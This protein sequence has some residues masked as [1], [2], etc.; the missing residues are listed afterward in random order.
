MNNM[1][2]IL[3]T[4]LFNK[5]ALRYLSVTPRERRF[6]NYDKAKNILL[7]FESDYAEKNQHIHRVIKQ[8]RQ[9][10]KKVSAWGFID[11]KQVETAIF[12]EFRILHHKQTDFFHRPLQ[13]YINELQHSPFDLV[14]DLTVNPVVPLQYLALYAISSFKTGIRK[15]KLPIYDFV[16]DLENV[17]AKNESSDEMVT[18]VDETYLYNQ[19]IFY[20]KRIQTTD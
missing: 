20:I 14:I 17:A 5:R 16:L 6:V 8:M 4:Y 18:A 13:S 12:P 11:K 3:N 10:G 2:K 7:L 19:I 9:D 15:S 1:F